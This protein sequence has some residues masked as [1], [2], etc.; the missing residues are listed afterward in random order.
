MEKEKNKEESNL[1][2][3]NWE[4]LDDFLANYLDHLNHD[5]KAKNSFFNEL[6]NNLFTVEEQKKNI[7][8]L[9][10]IREKLWLYFYKEKFKTNSHRS[11]NAPEIKSAEPEKLCS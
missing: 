10:I 7:P 3:N 11:A 6:F 2:I 1:I 4:Y 5:N 8:T 9:N